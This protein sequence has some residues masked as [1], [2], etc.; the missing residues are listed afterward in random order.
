M[1]YVSLEFV[2]DK[3]EMLRILA[4]SKENNTTVGIN[5]HLLGSGTHITSV[6]DILPYD[7]DILVILKSYDITGH[8]LDRNKLFLTEI[9]SVFPFSSRFENPFIKNLNK[10]GHTN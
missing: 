1:N 7:D 6:V 4:A 9:R 3:S 8:I 10:T 5:S 2:S